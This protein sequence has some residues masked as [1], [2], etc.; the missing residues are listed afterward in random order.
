MSAQHE[1]NHGADDDNDAYN[2]REAR[3]NRGSLTGP[4]LSATLHI[5]TCND[6]QQTEDRRADYG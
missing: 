1:R 6:E 5:Q 3:E 4:K 2:R